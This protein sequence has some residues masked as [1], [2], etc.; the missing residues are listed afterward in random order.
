MCKALDQHESSEEIVRLNSEFYSLIP[1]KLGKRKEEV[2]RNVI[3]NASALEEKQS[4]L[5]LMRDLVTMAERSGH[6]ASIK[7]EVDRRYISLGC[8][9]T[10]LEPSSSKV[11][12]SEQCPLSCF[13]LMR[14]YMLLLTG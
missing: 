9:I 12:M 11:Q 7:S 10:Q 3:N 6:W 2:Q 8:A 14:W 4:L 5:Q 13:Y 1:H